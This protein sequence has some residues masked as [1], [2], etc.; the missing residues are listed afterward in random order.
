MATVLTGLEA[1]HL[2]ARQPSPVHAKVMICTLTQQGH[3]VLNRAYGEVNVL[4]RALADAFSPAEH[5][6]LC[7]LLERATTVLI[8]QTRH[9]GSAGQPNRDE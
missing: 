6:A 2:I 9:A 3:H 5:S 4:E 1:K 8:G 7:D